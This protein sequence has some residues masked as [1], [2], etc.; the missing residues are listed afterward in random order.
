[1]WVLVYCFGTAWG[2]TQQQS[3]F[4]NSFLHFCILWEKGDV[5]ASWWYQ[6][7]CSGWIASGVPLRQVRAPQVIPSLS[8]PTTALTC[9]SGYSRDAQEEWCVWF[10]FS[11]C[12]LSDHH[13][14]YRIPICTSLAPIP[15]IG[16]LALQG[17]IKVYR[18]SCC[19]M[20]STA[21]GFLKRNTFC[22]TSGFFCQVAINPCRAERDPFVA[23]T[24]SI[25]LIS[26]L[27]F[28]QDFLQIL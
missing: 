1:M 14:H 28:F 27:C 15:L 8:P 4:T 16:P 10:Y 6:L 9:W 3:C 20:P 17:F 13:L 18:I 5:V 7:Q 26:L 12:L 19:L 22:V 11:Q 21:A 24:I 25:S 2:I 23:G